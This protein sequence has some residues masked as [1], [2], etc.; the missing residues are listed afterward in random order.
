MI[1]KLQW[2][3]KLCYSGI[4]L[5]LVDGIAAIKKRKQSGRLPHSRSEVRMG[6]N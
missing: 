4:K 1:T 2:S 6:P 5:P 3:I